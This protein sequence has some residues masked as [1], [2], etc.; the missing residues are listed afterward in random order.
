MPDAIQSA[1]MTRRP[2]RCATCTSSRGAAGT[3][4]RGARPRHRGRRDARARRPQRRGQEHAAEAD[5]RP[6]RAR[7]RARCSSR[8]ATTREWNPF[9][10]RRRIGYVLQEIGLFPHMTVAA[11]RRGRAEAARLGRRRA[12]TRASPRCSSSSACRPPTYAPRPALELSGGQRQRVGVARALAADPPILL[13]DEPFGALD[14]VTRAELHREFRRIQAQVRKTVVIVTHDMAEA[15]ALGDARRRARR[16]ASSRSSTRRASWRARPI[17]ASGRCSSRCSRRRALHVM[18][19]RPVSRGA[20][21]RVRRRCSC[22]TSLL[23]GASTLAAIAIGVPVGMLAARRPRL[24]APV[25]WLANVVQTI[26]SLAMFGF[27]LPLPFIGGLGARVAIVVLI[28]YALLPIIRTTIAGIRGVDASSSRPGTAL[29]MTPR[30][31]LWQVRAAAGAAV[32]RRRHPR[33]RGDRRRHGDDRRRGRRGRPRRVHLPRPVDGRPDGDP[34][35]RGA[36]GDRSRSPSTARCC[37][38]SARC[39]RRPLA[40][41]PLASRRSPRSSWSS[42]AAA[43]FALASGARDT[44]DPRRLEELHRADHSRRARRAAARAR[45][46]LTV[47]RRLNLGGTF[48]CD[49]ALRSGDIDVYVEYTGTA[50]TAVFK[51]PVETDPRARARARPAA[52]T[53]TAG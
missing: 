44:R 46:G 43:A 17:H 26:P 19:A 24:G 32:D 53:P 35:R 30:Q 42:L 1:L 27:L 10:L 22:S 11:Q 7:P 36:G 51:K 25:V 18:S 6:D 48:I 12:S 52:A 38:P 33:R 5:Q 37:S 16:R 29:G 34:R 28:L 15:F 3:V 50:D 2:F 21:R 20:P 14:P 40:R 8:G 9:E 39:A 31:L 13:M 45:D 47:E 49:R 41:R 23:V 4:L